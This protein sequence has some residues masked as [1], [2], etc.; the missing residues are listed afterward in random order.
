MRKDIGEFVKTCHPC[1]LAKQ[2]TTVNPGIGHFPVPD[3]R[4]E[5]IH[6]DIVGPLPESQGHRYLLSVV[7]RCSR[8]I[9]AYPL[10]RASSEEVCQAFVQFVSRFGLCKVAVSDNG[11]AF[12]ANLFKD[13][14]EN[15]KFFWKI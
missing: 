11:N 14:M 15:L 9:E 2:A 12:I 6:I 7:D 13:L 10:V 4:F 3:R 1:Q 8:W 5:Y